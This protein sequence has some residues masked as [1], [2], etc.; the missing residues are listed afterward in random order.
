MG[1]GLLR[2]AA[3]RRPP[4]KGHTKV[5]RYLYDDQYDNALGLVKDATF[6]AEL[7]AVITLLSEGASSV[8]ATPMTAAAADGDEE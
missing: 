2:H 4:Q 5:A 1:L 7:C 8:A 3:P 6:A